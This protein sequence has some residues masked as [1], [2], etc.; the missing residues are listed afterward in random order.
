MTDVDNA[1]DLALLT[2]T[3]AQAKSLFHSLEQAARC[4]S[5]HVNADKTEF[6]CSKQD[7]AISTL[8]VKPLKLV[9]LF[10]YLGSNISSTKSDFDVLIEKTWTAVETLTKRG[11]KNQDD[12]N[13]RM[14]HV[15]LKKS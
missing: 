6:M 11:E 5:L 10:P 1:D 15:L 2:N 7:G 8:N 3:P 4:I 9:D 14:L 12:Y 13:T